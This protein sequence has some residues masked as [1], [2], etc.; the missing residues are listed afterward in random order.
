MITLKAI[1]ANNG[2]TLNA[3]GEP[4]AYKR[5]YQV[6]CEDLAIIPVYKFRKSQLI[7]FLANIEA[8]ACLGLWIDN[9]KVYIDRSEY[10]SVK[11]EALKLG[12]ARNQLSIWNWKASEA[13][14]C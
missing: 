2:A 1:K 11:R 5:G 8:G 4:I 12:K 6:S 10:V 13:I 9:N 3:M 7:E 14:A